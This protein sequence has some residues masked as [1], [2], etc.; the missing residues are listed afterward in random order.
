LFYR[1]LNINCNF[2]YYSRLSVLFF[3]YHTFNEEQV[4]ALAKL[5]DAAVAIDKI[6]SHYYSSESLNDTQKLNYIIYLI[7][8]SYVDVNIDESY[9]KILTSDNFY[10]T[11]LIPF[12]EIFRH[13]WQLSDSIQR[14]LLNDST[15][16]DD[17]V[18]DNSNSEGGNTIPNILY[19]YFNY[20]DKCPSDL[21]RH[22][23]PGDSDDSD[24]MSTFDKTIIITLSLLPHY[25]HHS[26]FSYWEKVFILNKKKFLFYYI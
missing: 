5:N 20:I 19:S 4:S 21:L 15:Q 13:F 10:F 14:S 18:T 12:D 16:I 7:R 6:F 1:I 23:I 9:E 11:K 25:I 8:F 26:L 24:E 2:S 3:K 17:V 22:Q